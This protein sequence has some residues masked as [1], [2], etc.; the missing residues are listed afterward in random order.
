MQDETQECKS[1]SLVIIRIEIDDLEKNTLTESSSDT[2]YSNFKA[3]FH[4]KSPA[5]LAKKEPKQI[6][7]EYDKES[8]K[9]FIGKRQSQLIQIETYYFKANFMQKSSNNS[10][11]NF[12]SKL[13]LLTSNISFSGLKKVTNGRKRIIKSFTLMSLF[14]YIIKSKI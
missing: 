12:D 14:N 1:V 13:K 6:A 5:C 3:S 10:N 11:K 9:Q 7:E 4:Y 2:T 8:I